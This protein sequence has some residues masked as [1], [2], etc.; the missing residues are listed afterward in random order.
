MRYDLYLSYSGRKTYQTCPRKYRCAYVLKKAAEDD[1][2]NTIFGICI[3]KIFE[4]FYNK[5]LWA[6]P[7]VEV[8]CMK[9]VDDVIN[10]LCYSGKTNVSA[11]PDFIDSLRDELRRFVPP[12]IKTIREHKLLTPH[13]RSEIDLTVDYTSKKHGLTLR[14]GG[15][16]DFVHRADSVWIIDGKGSK[17]RERYIDSHQLIWYAILHYMKY[18]IAPSRL[19]FLYYK[20]PDD[21]VQWI[22]YDE[23]SM[24]KDLEHTFQVASDI[25]AG[26]F[27]TTPSGECRLCK[28]GYDCS[29]GVKFLAQKRSE[30]RELIE[31]GDDFELIQ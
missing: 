6:R 27:E 5:K 7:D 28:Y 11:Y 19:G 13:S 16:A 8:A 9:S 26:K 23:N 31:F 15:R 22:M 3:G 10:E 14:L 12:T 25:L 21:P 1:P 29:D 18:H 30:K 4:W 2:R 20:F 17:H 24:R